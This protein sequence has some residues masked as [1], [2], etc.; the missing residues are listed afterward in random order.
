M[1]TANEIRETGF[2]KAVIGGSKEADVDEFRC[3]VAA[4]F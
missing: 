4:D 1:F 3:A 2:Q